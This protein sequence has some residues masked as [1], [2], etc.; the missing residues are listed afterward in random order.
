V[1]GALQLAVSREVEHDV[2]VVRTDPLARCELA[3]LVDADF[4]R[5]A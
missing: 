4:A 1:E 3:A 2:V 5:L